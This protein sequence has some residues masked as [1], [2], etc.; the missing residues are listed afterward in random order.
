[1]A[2][3]CSHFNSFSVCKLPNADAVVGAGFQIFR[4]S[5]LLIF[6]CPDCQVFRFPHL[7][8]SR[9][10]VFR[11]SNFHIGQDRARKPL[12]LGIETVSMVAIEKSTRSC[13]GTRIPM[14]T[15][16]EQILGNLGWRPQNHGFGVPFEAPF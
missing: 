9:V 3:G 5:N 12:L 10:S 4:F 2:G 1:M 8:I 6:R 7:Q 15:I 11:N 16:G 14:A 13:W